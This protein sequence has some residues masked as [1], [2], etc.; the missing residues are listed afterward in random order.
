MA[1][2]H[3]VA[4]DNSHRSILESQ[5]FLGLGSARFVS[6][7]CPGSTNTQLLAAEFSAI[8]YETWN[9]PLRVSGMSVVNDPH[10]RFGKTF[11][12][13]DHGVLALHFVSEGFPEKLATFHFV[14]QESRGMMYHGGTFGSRDKQHL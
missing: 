14:S 9:T 10:L 5:S 1:Y 8:Y 12:T 7:R 2:N 6:D 13:D 3:G 4:H 11:L